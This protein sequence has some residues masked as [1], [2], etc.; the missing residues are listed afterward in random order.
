MRPCIT[1]ILTDVFDDDYNSDVN[2]G[3]PDTSDADYDVPLQVLLDKIRISEE[4]LIDGFCYDWSSDGQSFLLNS[5]GRRTSKIAEV[6]LHQCIANKK[7]YNDLYS[8]ENDKEIV[9]VAYGDRRSSLRVRP[10]GNYLSKEV[11]DVSCVF[12]GCHCESIVALNI[13]TKAYHKDD[14]DLLEARPRDV[15]VVALDANKILRFQMSPYEPVYLSPNNV[16]A[17]E[18]A[19]SKGLPRKNWECGATEKFVVDDL[20]REGRFNGSHD[21]RRELPFM[22]VL[23]AIFGEEVADETFDELQEYVRSFVKRELYAYIEWSRRPGGGGL[24]ETVIKYYMIIP[25]DFLLELRGGDQGTGRVCWFFETNRSSP[26]V[27]RP[28]SWPIDGILETSTLVLYV[29]V[30]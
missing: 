24:S 9:G 5:K 3:Q 28:I 23:R 18:I 1:L 2:N 30:H 25:S 7:L 10:E 8:Y 20:R 13:H 11:I 22:D 27:T 4:V 12:C 14:F 26:S 17:T 16:K 15:V 21:Q 19:I 6:L 29:S